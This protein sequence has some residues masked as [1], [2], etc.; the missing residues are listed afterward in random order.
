VSLANAQSAWPNKPLRM[1]IAFP[2][3]GPTDIVSR[4]IAAEL[5]RLLGQQVLVE[6]RPGAGGNL[7]AEQA[8]RAA[9][10]G[11]TLFYNTSAIT[12]APALYSKLNY[13]PQ[14]DFATVGLAA[15][16]PLVLVINPQVPAKNLREFV[17]WAKSRKGQINYGSSGSGTI[18][19]LAAAQLAKDAGFVATHVPYKGSAPG[20]VDLASGQ[21]QF[22]VDTINSTLPMIREGRLR[23]IAVATSKRSSVLPELPTIAESLIPGFEMSA[24]Q[25]LVVPS[26]TPPAIIAR[27]NTELQKVLASSE[28]RSKLLATGTEI[29][30]GTPEQYNQ[31]MQSELRRFAQLAREAGA[32]I[33]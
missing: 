23:A 30:G 16:V 11:Y 18:T 13:D 9:A 32:Q 2:P 26:G 14:K 22:M 1:L 8:A 4:V 6:N 24:W 3:G 28:V 10:D 15:T 12:I 5:S 7:G 25:G 27:L 20:M 21:V 33:D 29:L 19:H 17:D 31:F